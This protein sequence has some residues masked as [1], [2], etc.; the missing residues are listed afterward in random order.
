MYVSDDVEIQQFCLD[1][2]K[3]KPIYKEVSV[4]IKKNSISKDRVLFKFKTE[5]LSYSVVENILT[6]YKF[7]DTKIIEL[8]VAAEFIL[9]SIDKENNKSV[10]KVYAEA[11]KCDNIKHNT[12]YECIKGFKWDSVSNLLA[13][14]T[15]YG[16]IATSLDNVLLIANNCEI[17]KEEIPVSI[18]NRCEN[19]ALVYY[20]LDKNTNRKSFCISLQD[21]F[22]ENLNDAYF[23]NLL[24]DFKDCNI[25]HFQ[26]GIDKNQEKFITFYFRN[27]N[28]TIDTIQK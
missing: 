24:V 27:G 28:I 6:R 12:L 1:M 19:G 14:T 3:L 18:L 22:L 13:E 7:P 15:Y 10:F 21:F 4:K 9:F 5:E 20:V 16:T 26:M 2:I 17:Q 23:Q 8:L 11:F 25:R